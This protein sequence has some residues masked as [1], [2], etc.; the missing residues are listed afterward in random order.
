MLP[1]VGIKIVSYLIVYAP[2]SR[3]PGPEKEKKRKSIKTKKLR[4]FKR[5]RKK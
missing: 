3:Q 1:D 2:G 5:T 4:K